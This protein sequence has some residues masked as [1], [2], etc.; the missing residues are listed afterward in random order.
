[1]IDDEGGDIKESE[2]PNCKRW[3]CAQCKVPWHSGIK[4]EE[5]QKLNKNER[6]KEDIMLM[7]LAQNK[8]CRGVLSANST[9]R[10]QLVVSCMYMKCRS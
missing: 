7:Q 5:F 9:L 3:F 10:N 1:M 4:C 6:E 8:G 2:S